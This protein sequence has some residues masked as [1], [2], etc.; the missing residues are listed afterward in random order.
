MPASHLSLAVPSLW[1][2]WFSSLS[3]S[4]SVSQSLLYRLRGSWALSSLTLWVL[5]WVSY[6]AVSSSAL[7]HALLPAPPR[8]HASPSPPL[9]SPFLISVSSCLSLPIAACPA[10]DCLCCCHL[11]L[12]VSVCHLFPSV[13]V[14][15]CLCSLCLHLSISAPLLSVQC[16]PHVASVSTLLCICPR[17]PFLFQ[18]GLSP[19]THQHCAWSALPTSQLQGLVFVLERESDWPSSDCGLFG[20]LSTPGLLCCVWVLDGGAR[21]G[22]MWYTDKAR[23]GSWVELSSGQKCP[24]HSCNSWDKVDT[25]IFVALN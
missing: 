21:C 25:Q 3:V 12:S 14:A 6:S 10:A 22:V 8:L 13:T 24:L 16:S 2:F 7:P 1:M 18:D 4:P 5:L 20:Q 23:Q 15:V 19:P 17:F 9:F 11:S